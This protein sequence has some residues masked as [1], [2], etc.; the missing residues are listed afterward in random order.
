M[1]KNLNNFMQLALLL[2]F[3]EVSLTAYENLYTK[4]VNLWLFK[5]Q[6]GWKLELSINFQWKSDM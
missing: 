4:I 2:D 6:Y 1:V 5:D 3:I